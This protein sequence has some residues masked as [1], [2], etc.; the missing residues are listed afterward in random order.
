M[1]DAS[2][3]GAL[4]NKTP[5]EAWELV[6]SVA[7]NNQL[8]KTRVA[9]ST[10][11]VFEV[12]PSESTILA[13]SLYY[14]QPQGWRDNQ[15]NQWNWS[16]QPQQNQY[17]QPY[18]FS[19]PQNPKNPRYQPPHICQTYSQNPPTNTLPSNYEEALHSFQQE[20]RELREAQKREE[21]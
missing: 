1:T 2:S 5:D 21:A 8:F 15:Q 20:N 19:Q 12:A 18:T 10:K 13:K 4:M 3:G 7:D 9:T 6:E 14:A 11:G 17:R 16:Q